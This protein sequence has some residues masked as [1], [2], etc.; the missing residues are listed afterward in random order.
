MKELIFK[1]F[2]VSA[3]VDTL[4]LHKSPGSRAI[5]EFMNSHPQLQKKF[6]TIMDTE[7]TEDEVTAF[8]TGKCTEL[9][10]ELKAFAGE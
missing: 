6:E 5:Q 3:M 4:D 9:L 1:S 7:L 8:V 2:M 10:Q